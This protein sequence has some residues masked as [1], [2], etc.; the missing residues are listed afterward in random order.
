MTDQQVAGYEGFVDYFREQAQTEDIYV[1]VTKGP[2]K[3]IGWAASLSTLETF[4]SN[5]GIEGDIDY[6]DIPAFVL[7]FPPGIGSNAVE[8]AKNAVEAFKEQA[9]DPKAKIA[10]NA[11]YVTVAESLRASTST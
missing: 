6:N 4:I 7:D 1:R 2:E 9:K 5:A 3:W 11:G 10:M 8:A